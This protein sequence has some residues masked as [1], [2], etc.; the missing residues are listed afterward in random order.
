MWVSGG[1][2]PIQEQWVTVASIMAGRSDGCS[3]GTSAHR[4]T[5]SPRAH[6]QHSAC[7][8]AQD[9]NISPGA[10]RV[11]R[12]AIMTG[13]GTYFYVSSDEGRLGGS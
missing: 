11:P 3:P 13:V 12:T 7:P 2:G 8:G 4:H 1:V 9:T 5:Y 6:T 10:A